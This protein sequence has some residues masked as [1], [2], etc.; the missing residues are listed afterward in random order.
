MRQAREFEEEDTSTL[1]SVYRA[2]LEGGLTHPWPVVRAREIDRW[3]HDGGYQKI[4][5]GEYQRRADAVL[6]FMQTQGLDT[7]RLQ[8]VGFGMQRPVADNVTAEGRS[9]NRRVEF[10]IVE[11][12]TQ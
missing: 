9:K 4:I 11:Q 10:V 3:I 7:R 6:Y 5:D 8:A 2:M 1:E 12:N